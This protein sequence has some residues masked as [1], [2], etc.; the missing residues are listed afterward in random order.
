MS[1]LSEDE[2]HKMIDDAVRDETERCALLCEM[3]A[4]I[5]LVSATKI[6]TAGTFTARS[7]WPPFKKETFVAPKWEKAAQEMEA[8]AQAFN[9]VGHGCRAGWDPRKIKPDEKIKPTFPCFG[10][11]SPMD[12]GSW[13]CCERG[14]GD[15]V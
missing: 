8:V 1:D 6:R 3:R 10:C 5:A 11:P 7:I 4:D 15:W 12:C 14:H 9:S 2:L 13:Q